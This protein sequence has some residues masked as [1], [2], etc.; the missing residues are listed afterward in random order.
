VSPLREP[1][2]LAGTGVDVVY[3]GEHTCL[4]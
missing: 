3:T 1:I 2:G 4:G